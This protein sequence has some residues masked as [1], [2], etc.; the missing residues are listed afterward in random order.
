MHYHPRGLPVAVARVSDAQ[1]DQIAGAQSAVQ[2]QV[3]QGKVAQPASHLRADADC[4]DLLKPE[5]RLL[6]DEL[7]L[8][9]SFR[10]GV[11]T[12]CVRRDRLSV[13]GDSTLR[14][15]LDYTSDPTSGTA[16]MEKDGR[17]SKSDPLRSIDS[18]Q[19]RRSPA[20][21]LTFNVAWSSNRDSSLTH[22]SAGELDLP[23]LAG[24]DAPCRIP[25]GTQGIQNVLRD[26]AVVEITDDPVV[27]VGRIPDTVEVG[28]DRLDG[29]I[30]SI[31]GI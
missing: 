7:A 15:V 11:G 17:G 1:P 14:Q 26:V 5:R 22:R 29:E 13:E 2:F 12:V 18:A 28:H 31:E 3:G 10:L 6:A 23:S 8:V 20:R 9:S 27:I 19:S 25:S 24:A 30:G 21:K 16:A 4:P